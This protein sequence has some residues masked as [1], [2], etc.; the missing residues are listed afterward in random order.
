M[1]R[2]PEAD[3]LLLAHIR[4]CIERIRDY[5]GGD[6]TKFLD[7][8]LVQD[9]VVRNLQILAESTQRLSESLKATEPAVPWRAIAGFRNVLAHNYLG[10]DLTA[11]WSV[12]EM[13]LPELSSAIER[14]SRA[15]A[16]TGDRA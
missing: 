15:I 3:R 5:T 13:D 6:R 11:V 4:Q 2:R 7:S 9:A 16:A 14:M 10:I 12:V 8:H 1:T